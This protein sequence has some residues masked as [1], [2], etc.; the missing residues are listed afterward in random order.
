M[1]AVNKVTDFYRDNAILQIEPARVY[2]QFFTREADKIEPTAKGSVAHYTLTDRGTADATPLGEYAD[3]VG[4]QVL[5]SYDIEVNLKEYGEDPL[6]INRHWDLVT[7]YNW[8][9]DHIN[10]CAGQA[11]EVWNGLLKTQVLDTIGDGTATYTHATGTYTLASGASGL[12]F[13]GAGARTTSGANRAA[14]TTTD[15]YSAAWTDYALATLRRRGV[16][17][18]MTS[19]G[20]RFVA[21][22]HP[23]LMANVRAAARAAGG[24]MDLAVNSEDAIMLK[25]GVVG[26]WNGCIWVEDPLSVYAAS[27]LGSVNVFP[28]TY[29]GEDFLA[30]PMRKVADMPAPPADIVRIP[31][32]EFMEIRLSPSG[33]THGR[34]WHM[35][36]YFE[37]G[38]G[39]YNPKAQFRQEFYTA[40]QTIA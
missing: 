17:P 5:T 36:F 35:A 19:K 1:A 13:Y 23:N 27:G 26:D 32:N 25:N 40:N 30:V 20:P 3:A 28:I 7:V 12:T 29:A 37:A 33:G 24:G 11:I 9:L 31:I 18:Y 10:V 8:F 6:T 21:F 16:K 2:D 22:A 39:I 38:C 4:S 15:T 14:V 34:I